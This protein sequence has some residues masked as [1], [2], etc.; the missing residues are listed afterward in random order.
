MSHLTT[1]SN[2]SLVNCNKT[3]L[4][5]S[6]KELGIE[7][8]YSNR[9]IKNQWITETVDAAIVYQGKRIAVGLNF[10]TN[11]EGQEEVEVAGDFYGTGLNQTELTN[12][13]A[14][15]YQKNNVI[16]KCKSQRWFINEKDIVTKENGDIVIQAYRYA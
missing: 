10:K 12:K 14:Q 11:A 8:D 1:Y 15:T 7:L 3:L 4:E 16:E 5:T 6:L 13:I 9:V 2:N